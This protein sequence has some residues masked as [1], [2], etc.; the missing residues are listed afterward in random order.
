V[1]CLSF[2]KHFTIYNF[3]VT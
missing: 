3:V 2:Y 1:A